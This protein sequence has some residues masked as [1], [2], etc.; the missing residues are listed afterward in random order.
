M[1]RARADLWIVDLNPVTAPRVRAA[2]EA[3]RR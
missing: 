1:T 3:A 2:I